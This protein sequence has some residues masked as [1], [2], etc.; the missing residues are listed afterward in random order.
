MFRGGKPPTGT[1]IVKANWDSNPWFPA[2][3]DQERRDCIQN[4]PDQYGHIW[5]GEYATVLSGAYFANELRNARK[6]KRIGFV[7]L[8]PLMGIK[9]FWDIGGTGLKSDATSIW[10]AQFVGRQINWIDYYEARHQPLAAHV[11]WLKDKGYERALCVLPHD[12][13]HGEKVYAATYEGALKQA[14]FKTKVVPN[15]GAGAAK[16]R[17]EAARRLFPMMFFHEQNT[18]AGLDALGWYHEKI[19]ESR[20]LGLGPDH[21]WSSH[22]ADAFGLGCIDY[23]AP[24]TERA[25]KRVSH[26][27]EGGWMG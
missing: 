15:Q 8:D 26:R 1:V 22:A 16:M 9:A 7:A 17:V 27:I 20:S 25:A 2:E 18:Q 14:G 11:N 3:L 5:E 13:E 12:G 21:D 24:K 4:Q 10:I 19:D 23:E 6:E